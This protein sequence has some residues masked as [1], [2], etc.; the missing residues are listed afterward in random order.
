MKIYTCRNCDQVIYFDNTVCMS[1]GLRLGFLPERAR[2]SALEPEDGDAWRALEEPK[3]RFRYCANARQD[4]CNWLVPASGPETLCRACRYNRTIPDLSDPLNLTRWRRIEGAKH[5]LFYSLIRFDLPLAGRADAP[6]NGLA[7]DFLAE[8]PS[9]TGD[10]QRVMTGHDNGLITINVAE[11]DDVAREQVR[12]AMGEPYRTLLGHFRHEIGHYYWDRLVRD[13]GRIEA[14]RAMFGDE[15][16]D[17]ASALGAHYA[18]GPTPN[19]Q[20]GFVSGY[21]AAHAWEDFAETWA[22]YFHMV[23]TLETARAFGVSLRPRAPKHAELD[24]EVDFDPYRAAG[25]APLI[26]AWRPLTIAVNSLNRSMGQPDL[27]PFI[28]TPAVIAKLEFVHGLIHGR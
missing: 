8:T 4:V 5:H 15:S 10:T 2:L 21:A 12:A 1:C 9:G 6:L 24:A 17:Y 25:V 16:L 19:W 28:L 13:G 23:D 7:F 11:A 18:S 22:H 3:A 27:Y 26:D 14:F 20:D